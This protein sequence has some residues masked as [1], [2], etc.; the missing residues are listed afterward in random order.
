MKKTLS[1][2]MLVTVMLFAFSA[3]AKGVYVIGVQHKTLNAEE[4]FTTT[5]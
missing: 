2:L 1:I 3:L 4:H 5:D